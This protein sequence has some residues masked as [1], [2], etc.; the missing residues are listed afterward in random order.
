M[1]LRMSDVEIISWDPSRT[2]EWHAFVEESN[3][4]TVFHRIDFLGYHPAGRFDFRHLM[5]YQEGA[6]IALLPGGRAGTGF[7]SPVGASFGGFVFKNGISLAQAESVVKAFLAWCSSTGIESATITPPMQCYCRTP[8]EVFEFMLLYQGFAQT[9]S[10]YSSVIDL[11][12]VTSKE[13][14]SRNT[15]HKIN[16][17]I[18]KNVR[19]EESENYALFYPILEENKAKFKVKPTHS[20]AELERIKNIAPGMMKLFLA[21]IG[22]TPVAGELLFTA[23]P[24][25]VLNFYTMHK[26]EFRNY[27]AVNLLVEHAIRWSCSKGFAWYDYGVSADTASPNP[28]EPSRSLIEYKES[29]GSTGCIRRTFTKKI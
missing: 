20:L 14:L 22:E 5:F 15:R 10:L 13:D 18:N 1:A 21:Y 4:G 9:G 3:N 2:A 24:R 17:A 11:S 26:Y 19:I 25:C 29:M 7:R 23:N 28:L 27:F 6:L 8:D 12:M 16:K